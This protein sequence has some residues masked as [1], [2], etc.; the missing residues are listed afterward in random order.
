MRSSIQIFNSNSNLNP[1]LSPQPGKR[2]TGTKRK[3]TMI[4]QQRRKAA[5]GDTLKNNAQPFQ[6]V[7]PQGIQ[8]RTL[9]NINI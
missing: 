2:Q 8:Q 3:T 1:N 5:V 9:T 4:R 7:K 6:N